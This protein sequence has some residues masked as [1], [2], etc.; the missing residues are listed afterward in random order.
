MFILP[1]DYF[2]K[3]LFSRI[4]HLLPIKQRYIKW[5][6]NFTELIYI[7]WNMYIP[8]EYYDIGYGSVK[9]ISGDES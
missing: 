3:E 1:K 5:F 8:I 4:Y 6:N 7:L 2:A 9:Q